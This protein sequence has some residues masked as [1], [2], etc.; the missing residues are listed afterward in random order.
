MTDEELREVCTDDVAYRAML[1]LPTRPSRN[2][3]DRT[4]A[5]S[6]AFMRRLRGHDR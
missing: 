3:W 1:M 4:M 5:A 6:R 2:E